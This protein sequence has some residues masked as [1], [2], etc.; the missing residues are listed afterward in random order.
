MRSIV[1]RNVNG[2]YLYSYLRASV[3]LTER[4]WNRS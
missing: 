3:R 4:R 2:A 1:D